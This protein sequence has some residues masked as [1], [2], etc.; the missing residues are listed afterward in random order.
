MVSEPISRFASCLA[1]VF[2]LLQV[3][4]GLPVCGLGPPPF[5]FL[6]PRVQLR[7]NLEG[8]PLPGANVELYFGK[9]SP[10]NDLPYETGVTDSGGITF[11]SELAWATF[12][13]RV[14]SRDHQIGDFTLDAPLNKELRATEGKFELLAA[15]LFP[16]EEKPCCACSV[17]VDKTLQIELLALRGVVVDP[18]GAIIPKAIIDVYQNEESKRVIVQLTTDDAGRF[19]SKLAPGKYLVIFKACGFDVQ[20]VVVTVGTDGSRGMQVGLGVGGSCGR[21][22]PGNEATITPLNQDSLENRL[23]TAKN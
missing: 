17:V 11:T 6:H 2:V 15:P 3:A 13:I 10:T 4:N 16:D 8:K 14:L 12:Y 19:D 21:R 7:F 23:L 1:A 5:P 20:K 18:M 22:R 9:P